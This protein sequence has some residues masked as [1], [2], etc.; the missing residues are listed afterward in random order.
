MK[1]S[2]NDQVVRNLYTNEEKLYDVRSKYY[3]EFAKVLGKINIETPGKCPVKLS[4]TGRKEEVVE[5]FKGEVIQEIYL[6]DV[7]SRGITFKRLELL[8]VREK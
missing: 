3:P 2:I 6:S 5:E 4:Y 7:G 8:P 1:F